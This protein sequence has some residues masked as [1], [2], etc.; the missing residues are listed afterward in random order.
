MNKPLSSFDWSLIQ[1]FLVVAEEGS[2]SGAA[3]A[4]GKS[5]PTLG[6]QIKTLEEGLGISLFARQARGFEL[7]DAGRDL[8]PAAKQMAEA[9][10]ALST[11]AAGRDSSISGTVRI[12]ASEFVSQYILPAI[13]AETRKEHP[14]IQIELHATDHADNLLFREADIAVR[15]YRPTQLEVI[16]KFLGLLRLGF[17]ASSSYLQEHG[18]PNSLEEMM[19]L[20]M[21]GYDASER[22]IRGAA[23]F[24]WEL[25]R[26][27][28]GVRCDQQTIHGELIRAG[29]GIGILEMGVANSTPGLEAVFPEFPMPALEVWLTTHEALR[30]VP[31]IRAV[32]SKLEAGLKP[33]LSTDSD[34]PRLKQPG[35]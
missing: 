2:L 23:E 1:S 10:A 25:K 4:S 21:I 14:E 22:L 9:A 33:W 34:V 28:F 12:T 13:I 3:R 6:R 16:T 26:S 29:C 11:I 5:Q 32:W 35:T 7:T 24:G 15:M 19:E 31:R 8:L 17:Y 27:D 30:N 18:R 20:D